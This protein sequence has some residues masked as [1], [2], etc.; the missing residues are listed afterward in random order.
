MEYD[1]MLATLFEEEDRAR[2]MASK[3]MKVSQESREAA[4]AERQ[5]LVAF[6]K[7]PME[8]HMAYEERAVFPQ[9][10]R[11]GL[12][13]EVQVALR[14]HAMIREDAEKLAAARP[15]DDVSQLIF[16]VARRMLHHT[17]FEGDYIYPELTYEAW[18]D[19]MKETAG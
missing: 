14:H 12:G 10:D 16:D 19:L 4:S 1:R 2:E 6:L 7:G 13:A 5:S 3:L 15:G 11:R 9:L 18:R 17:N 8:R